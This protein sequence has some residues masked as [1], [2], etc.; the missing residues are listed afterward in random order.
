MT[1]HQITRKPDSELNI[2]TIGLCGD[3]GEPVGG[4]WGLSVRAQLCPT[5]SDP[6][7]CSPPGSFVHGIFQTRVLEWGAIAFFLI[8]PLQK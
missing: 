4:L 6:T 3:D 2:G 7:D 1:Y 8:L 5:L